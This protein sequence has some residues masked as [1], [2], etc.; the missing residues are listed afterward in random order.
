MRGGKRPFETVLPLGLEFFSKPISDYRRRD[1][2]WAVY[3]FWTGFKARAAAP[4]LIFD[5]SVQAPQARHGR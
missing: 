5:G 4:A 3:A 1:R 2:E